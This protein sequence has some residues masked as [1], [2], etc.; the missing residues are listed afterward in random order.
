MVVSLF[1]GVVAVG[2][3]RVPED[4][5]QH[6]CVEFQRAELGAKGAAALLMPQAGVSNLCNA[7]HHAR[8]AACVFGVVSTVQHTMRMRFSSSSGSIRVREV[9]RRLRS[10]TL[11][12]PPLFS[13]SHHQLLRGMIL[14][15]SARAC[16]LLVCQPR[17]P[18]PGCVFRVPAARV[19]CGRCNGAS[20][21]VRWRRHPGVVRPTIS[22][23]RAGRVFVGW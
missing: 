1:H 13:A 2:V 23:P 12:S 17:P 3:N 18:C 22:E 4:G 14:V 9:Q 6:A 21:A 11:A 8:L 15:R 10:L 7:S 16:G 19:G 5:A 20:K